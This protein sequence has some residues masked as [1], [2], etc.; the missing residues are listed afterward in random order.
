MDP[1]VFGPS[2]S[3]LPSEAYAM[4]EKPSENGIL[5]CGFYEDHE[6]DGYEC[7]AWF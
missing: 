5:S 1:I 4:C 3:K 6:I 2:D 7:G